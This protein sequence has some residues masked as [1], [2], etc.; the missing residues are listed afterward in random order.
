MNEYIDHMV[1]EL[2]YQANVA[3]PLE[4]DYASIVER[5]IRDTKKIVT[6]RAIGAALYCQHLQPEQTE[7]CFLAFAISN[8]IDAAELEAADD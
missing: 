4:P 5:V 8:A 1:K 2:G 6:R 7:G 3:F